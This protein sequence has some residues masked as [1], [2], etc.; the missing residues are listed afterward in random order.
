MGLR[1]RGVY[2]S[3]PETANYGDVIIANGK[4][5]VYSDDWMEFGYTEYAKTSI[6]HEF[7]QNCPNCGG[8]INPFRMKCDFCGT[9]W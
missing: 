7:P 8:V 1:F 4:N 5:Y 9:Y 6:F 2:E 3:F